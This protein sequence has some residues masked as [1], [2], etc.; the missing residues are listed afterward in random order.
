[1]NLRILGLYRHRKGGLYLGLA[2]GKWEPTAE[3][4]VAYVGASGLWF[5]PEP[6]FRDG[7]FTRL[8]AREALRE[9][10]ARARD[11]IDRLR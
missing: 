11:A 2:V 3:P 9:L 4:A 6:L 1:M 10:A 5:R 7:R 8:S